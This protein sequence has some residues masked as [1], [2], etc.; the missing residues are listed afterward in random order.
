MCAA[1]TKIFRA[2][3]WRLMRAEIRAR[4]EAQIARMERE[5]GLR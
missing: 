3:C 4:G 2:R 5:S 1:T